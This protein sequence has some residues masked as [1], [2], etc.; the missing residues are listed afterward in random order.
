M[1]KQYCVINKMMT[2]SR[3]NYD[4]ET[5]PVSVGNIIPFIYGK[6]ALSTVFLHG[7]VGD[8]IDIYVTL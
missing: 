7:H 8:T 5:L 6:N 3:W 1:I 4:V 2:G